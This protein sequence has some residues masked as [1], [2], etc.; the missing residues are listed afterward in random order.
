M[1]G[2]T[3]VVHSSN[4]WLHLQIYSPTVH[5]FLASPKH[6]TTSTD[7]FLKWKRLPFNKQYLF[8]S[9]PSVP[10]FVRPSV[11]PFFSKFNSLFGFNYG[12]TAI[13]IITDDFTIKTNKNYKHCRLQ[14]FFP[15]NPFNPPRRISKVHD[16]PIFKEKNIICYFYSPK[17]VAK[18][19]KKSRR[20]CAFCLS[21][22]CLLICWLSIFGRPGNVCHCIFLQ[23]YLFQLLFRFYFDS[24]V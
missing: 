13:I 14:C 16:K 2:K 7:F 4:A 17:F 23:P 12:K 6:L 9:S 5:R 21:S 3:K 11:R 19:W 15:L 10:S 1:K 22:T 24:F 8:V 18:R 20:K